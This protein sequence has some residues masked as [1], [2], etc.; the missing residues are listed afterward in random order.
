MWAKFLSFIAKY[1]FLPLI[2][3]LITQWYESI[4]KKVQSKKTLEENQKKVETYE[5]DETN[6]DDVF[7]DLP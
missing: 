4:K 7:S 2:K 6:S 1:L 5:K 3:E